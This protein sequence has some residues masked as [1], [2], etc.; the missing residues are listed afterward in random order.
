MKSTAIIKGFIV[1]RKEIPAAFMASN[2]R[3]SPKFPNV[4]R[5]ASSIDKGRAIGTMVRAA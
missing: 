5:D 2:S 1:C 4:M 3:R